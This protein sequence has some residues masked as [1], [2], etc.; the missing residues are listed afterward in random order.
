LASREKE[1]QCIVGRKDIAFGNAQCPTLSDYA[2]GIDTL[3]FL[4]GLN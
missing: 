4:L 2:D 1:I 3:E